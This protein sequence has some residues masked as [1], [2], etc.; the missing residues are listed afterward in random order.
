MF[1]SA[2]RRRKYTLACDSLPSLKLI[3]HRRGL[4]LIQQ[5]AHTLNTLVTPPK[6]QVK[7]IASATGLYVEGA[8]QKAFGAL[9]S[10]VAG[11]TPGEH[12]PGASN[13]ST[14]SSSAHGGVTTTNSS[15]SDPATYNNATPTTDMPSHIQP[16]PPKV[17]APEDSLGEQR[18]ASGKDRSRTTR[19]LAASLRETKPT[20][21]G[22]AV[23]P[24]SIA[25]EVG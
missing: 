2:F 13:D 22:D 23:G 12:T 10:M 9:R 17:A 1:W 14:S 6:T 15:R 25:A 18:E 24:S 21:P 7:D 16:F 8:A 20:V 5:L 19:G 3:V 11:L 4:I